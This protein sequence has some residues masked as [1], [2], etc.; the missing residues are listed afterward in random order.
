MAETIEGGA[1]LAGDRWVNYEGKPLNKEQIV[2]AKK[3]HAEQQQQREAANLATLEAQ[4]RNDPLA[5]SLAHA[6]RPT[7]TTG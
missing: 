2:A 6:L 5:R 3:L 7:G 1:Y 4:A